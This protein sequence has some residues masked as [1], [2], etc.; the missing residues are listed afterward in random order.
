MSYYLW[1]F[2][3]SP[4]FD[5]AIG[6]DVQE[7]YD[8]ALEILNGEF[9][10]SGADHHAPF[11]SWMLAGMLA[12]TGGSIP[13]VRIPAR[14]E[15]RGLDRLFR[16][17]RADARHSPCCGLELLCARHAVSGSAFS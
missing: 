11:Y 15:F 4:L 3:A 1:Q 13:A 7:Y 8:R 6:P 12:V 5:A 14:A 16:R 17:S 10:P 2:R 9:F